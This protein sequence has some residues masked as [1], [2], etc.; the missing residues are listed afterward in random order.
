[1]SKRAVRATSPWD[2]AVELKNVS[3]VFVQKQHAGLFKR[4]LRRVD[5][6]S[7]VNLTIRRGEFVAYAG[8]NGAGKSTTFKL[9]CGMLMPDTGEVR[10]MGMEPVRSRVELMRR[11]GVLFGGRTELWWDHPVYRSFEWKRDVWD[12]PRDVWQRNVDMYSELLDLKPFLHTYVRELSL[13]QRMRA[14][15]AMMLLHDPELILLDEPTLGLDV[16]AKRRMMDCLRTL[17]R[18]RGA[19]ILVTSHD[20]DDLTAMAQRLLLLHDGRIA[21]DGAS[22]DLLRRTGDR[23]ILTLTRS[24]EAPLIDGAQWQSSDSGRH[25]YAF[26][27]ADVSR[28]LTSAARLADLRDIDITH[29]PI[30]E[31]IA[32]LF[33]SWEGKPS[34]ALD[35]PGGCNE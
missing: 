28:V 12:I 9:L 10:V 24:G 27:G 22:G 19:T 26:D 18:D 21:F 35:I 3:K 1:M 14:E 4:S 33:S 25:L 8:P 31:V 16:L 7:G 2:T 13:G 20:M 17:N 29:A 30:E 23:R 6:L 15:L 11:T 32:N 5:A 34:S